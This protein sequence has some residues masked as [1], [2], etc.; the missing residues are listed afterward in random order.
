MKIDTKNFEP[1]NVFIE[2]DLI[3]NFA[4][5]KV[6]KDSK[7]IKDDEATF[8]KLIH[9]D[10][11]DGVIEIKVLSRLLSNAPEHARG[12]IGLAFRINEA[13]DSFES[14]YIRPTNGRSES[15]LR[16]NRSVQYFSYPDFKFDVS[17]KDF[18]GE[19]ETYADM[20]LDEWIDLKI[21]VC[22]NQAKLFLNEQ[23]QPTLIV[24]DLKKGADNHGSIGLWVD[25][26]TEGFFRDLKI[27]NK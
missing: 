8:A 7:I 26:G 1:I 3:D 18:P 22:G 20:G 13:N 21:E 6:I 10:F 19:Y 5:L 16:R 23:V 24:N 12:F 27:T 11:Q 2:N 4:V 17:R 14:I 15:Q 9:S 25:I